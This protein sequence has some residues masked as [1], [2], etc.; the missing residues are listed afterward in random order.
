MSCVAA[1][2]CFASRSSVLCI[3][4]KGNKKRFYKEVLSTANRQY[5]LHLMTLGY[6]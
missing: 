5:E 2:Q 4:D 3:G 6:P 1:K